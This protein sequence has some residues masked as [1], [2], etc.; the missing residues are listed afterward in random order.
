MRDLINDLASISVSQHRSGVNRRIYKLIL[1]VPPKSAVYVVDIFLL[2]TLTFSTSGTDGQTL[3]SMPESNSIPKVFFDV[4]NA[5]VALFVEYQ[6]AFGCLHDIQ[7]MELATREQDSNKEYVAGLHRCITQDGE[8]DATIALALGSSSQHFDTRVLHFPKLWKRYHTELT[9]TR[10]GAEFWV[11]MVRIAIK[12][13]VLS[14]QNATYDQ[15]G[16]ENACSPWDRDTIDMD[17]DAWNDDVMKQA[18]EG[19]TWVDYESFKVL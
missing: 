17:I 18:E 6:I 9:R 3:K 16:T 5:S 1:F 10:S 2:G 11:Y 13:R 8:L 14:T 15:M 12:D 7:L 4:R 19:E